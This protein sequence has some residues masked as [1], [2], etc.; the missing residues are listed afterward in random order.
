MDKIVLEL[1]FTGVNAATG[2]IGYLPTAGLYTA[3]IVEFA[4]FEDSNRLYAYYMT[5][6]IR[7]SDSFNVGSTNALPFL[8]A[9]LES[10]QIPASKLDG[11]SKIP[12]HKLAGKTVYFNYVPPEMDSTG[13]KVQGSY[14]KYTYY[15]KARFVQMQEISAISPQDVEVESSNGAG[16]PV[17][18]AANAEEENFDFLLDSD[19]NE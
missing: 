17:A 7:H 9:M 14:P 13:K 2:G 11:K 3:K 16:A 10:A 18:Q 5:D 12:F 1:D 4:H 15:P 8:K 19:S 6:G